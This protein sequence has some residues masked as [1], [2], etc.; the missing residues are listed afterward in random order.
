MEKITNK[1]I[2]MQVFESATKALIG[3]R[4]VDVNYNNA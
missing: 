3:L 2:Q 4:R 1:S